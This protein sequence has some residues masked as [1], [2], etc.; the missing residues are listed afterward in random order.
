MDPLI[1]SDVRARDHHGDAHPLRWPLP[2]VFAKC[3]Q[4]AL[5]LH[6]VYP[7]SNSERGRETIKLPDQN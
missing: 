2:D 1:F 4:D 5:N 7:D 6:P 3:L